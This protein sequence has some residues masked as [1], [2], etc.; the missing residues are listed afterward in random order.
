M[1]WEL[2]SRLIPMSHNF[3]SEHR[4]RQ[5][6]HRLGGAFAPA[7]PAVRIRLSVRRG[8]GSRSSGPLHGQ[9]HPSS[10]LF[11]FGRARFE[12]WKLSSKTNQKPLARENA[13]FRV[14][15]SWFTHYLT[16]PYPPSPVCPKDWIALNVKTEAFTNFRSLLHG[17][18]W[19]D[20]LLVLDEGPLQRRPQSRAA[21]ACHDGLH[22]C[23]P[24]SPTSVYPELSI[25]INAILILITLKRRRFELKSAFVGAGQNW[26]GVSTQN[27]GQTFTKQKK[28]IC[29]NLTL[30]VFFFQ[31]P[32]AEF[33]SFN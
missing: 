6:L 20:V 16:F 19:T 15:F 18:Q 12:T 11:R 24:G 30:E 28:R 14:L 8:I 26:F 3:F 25:D 31:Q 2:V 10:R 27:P 33:E 32:S 21:L 22:S 4:L 9:P 7:E 29:D 23:L 17:Q 1:K 5:D 13:P